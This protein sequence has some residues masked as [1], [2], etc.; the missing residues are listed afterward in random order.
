MRGFSEGS[1]PMSRC[2]ILNDGPVG[3]V[4]DHRGALPVCCTY[5]ILNRDIAEATMPR[6]GK[7]VR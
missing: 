2:I 5:L 3:G 6:A 4:R 1:Q 7:E